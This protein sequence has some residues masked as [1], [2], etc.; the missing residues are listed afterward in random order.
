MKVLT[1]FTALRFIKAHMDVGHFGLLHSYHVAQQ[2]EPTAEYK[3]KLEAQVKQAGFTLNGFDALCDLVDNAVVRTVNRRTEHG[4]SVEVRADESLWAYAM[5]KVDSANKNWAQTV[6]PEIV[7][8]IPTA[9]DEKSVLLHSIDCL[10]NLKHAAN[11]KS[12]THSVTGMVEVL[13]QDMPLIVLSYKDE[14]ENEQEK[15]LKDVILSCLA[16]A[17]ALANHDYDA[18]CAMRDHDKGEET[19][20]D[21]YRMEAEVQTMQEDL[22]C[23]TANILNSLK[24]MTEK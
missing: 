1:I 18:E 23:L 20:F 7:I 21:P 24:E 14:N 6:M 9:A 12:V 4:A 19:E 2:V 15:P 16:K 13:T 10:E 22:Q 8:E 17:E 5:D 3:A 11:T